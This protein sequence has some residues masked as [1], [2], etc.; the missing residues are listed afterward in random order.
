MSSTVL[1]TQVR[2]EGAR[3]LRQYRGAF[4]SPNTRVIPMSRLAEPSSYKKGG[5]VK[6]SGWAKVHKG[7][8]IVVAGKILG[9]GKRNKRKTR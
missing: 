2:P 5:R 9:K 4:D 6:K 1:G 3:N 8:R 7:E